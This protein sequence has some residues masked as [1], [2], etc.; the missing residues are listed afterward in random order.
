MVLIHES[1]KTQGKFFAP[2]SLEE[3]TPLTAHCSLL[4]AHC[5]LLTKLSSRLILLPID[6]H[7]R[8]D[9][10]EYLRGASTYWS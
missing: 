8:N 3:I 6:H 4:T 7:L 10:P 2:Q 5:S 1:I 9:L